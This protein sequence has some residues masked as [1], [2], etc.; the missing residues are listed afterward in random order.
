MQVRQ[1]LSITARKNG[2]KNI[3]FKIEKDRLYAF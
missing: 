1:K 2:Y 3:I